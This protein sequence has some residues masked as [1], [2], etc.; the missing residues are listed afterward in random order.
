MSD[1]TKQIEKTLNHSMYNQIT[2]IDAIIPNGLFYYSDGIENGNE[3]KLEG[4]IICIIC[5][6]YDSRDDFKLK[7][8]IH[9]EYKD[10]QN[11]ILLNDSKK[12]NLE[13]NLSYQKSRELLLD[14]IT[15]G[16]P[17]SVNFITK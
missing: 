1:I 14:L 10:N 16:K 6:G 3:H 4:K 17:Y 5:K 13:V 2:K 15:K 8:N 9:E 11:L 12:K 7:I